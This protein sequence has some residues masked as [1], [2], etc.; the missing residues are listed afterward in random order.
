MTFFK[1]HPVT[2]RIAV[3]GP[4]R[5][6]FLQFRRDRM[7]RYFFSFEE[8]NVRLRDGKWLFPHGHEMRFEWLA[9]LAYKRTTTPDDQAWVMVNDVA[10]LPS[11]SG[12]DL[13][14]IA[15]NIGRYLHSSELGSHDL[16]AT[17]AA[18]SGPYRLNA[19]AVDIAFDIPTSEIRKRLR[20]RKRLASRME[21]KNLLRF[22]ARF[23]RAHWLMFRGRL[24]RGSSAE[25]TGNTAY[26]LLTDLIR[27]RAY[28]PT[29]RLTACL[30][31]AD[32]LHRLGRF[33]EAREMLT[34]HS[35]LMQSVPDR[36]LRAQFYL[37][38]AWEHQR[39][40]S[41][42]RSDRAVERALSKAA[43]YAE[44]SGDRAA[45]GL[46]AFRTGGYRT[47]KGEHLESVNQ[48]LLALESYLI[49]GDYEAVHSTL[50][51]IGSVIHRF[52]R[53]YYGEARQWLLLSIAV[54]RWMRVGR[55]DAHVEMIL[56]KIY[57]ECNNPVRSQ[58]LLAR[59][60]RIAAQAGNLIN[61]ADIRMVR[62][63]WYQRFGT[64]EQLIS[65]L[66]DALKTF[67]QISEFDVRQK[68][69]YMKREF[70]KVWD[71]VLGRAGEQ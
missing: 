55:D 7:A 62:G 23:V 40:S 46:L 13:R 17:A 49:T 18:W 3:N 14:H 25:A 42:V 44:N 31:A 8:R 2:F 33:K 53:P 38:L 63:F 9:L 1:S 16:V 59:A 41:G 28:S 64:T 50:G 51:N 66:V 45:L 58:W 20:L 32:V 37:R 26:N 19:S 56:G 29:L 36:S 5:L 57:A 15:N 24:R 60:E 39:G 30:S 12:R 35:R 52:G 11:W 65:T 27:D 54:G 10:R 6:Q 4:L 68:E 22:T 21:R 34:E 48:F 43:G 47:K 61:L 70:P 67:R 69:N 71:Y